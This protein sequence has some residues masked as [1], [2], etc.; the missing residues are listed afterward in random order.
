MSDPFRLLFLFIQG[1]VSEM[2]SQGKQEK[3]RVTI[4]AQ[5]LS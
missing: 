5:R 4:G 1:L 3:K 2:Q